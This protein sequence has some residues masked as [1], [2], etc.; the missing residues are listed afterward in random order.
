VFRYTAHCSADKS[1]RAA[2]KRAGLPQ[3]SF[4][5]CRHGFAT[6]MLRAG[7]DPVT[8]AKRGGWKTPQHVFS[9]YG[10]ASDDLT[11]TDRIAGTNL[12]QQQN[13]ELVSPSESKRYRK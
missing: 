6:A 8:I 13:G 3:L 1:W 11:I 12:T 7:V 10:H 4:H 5:S 9:T 2:I